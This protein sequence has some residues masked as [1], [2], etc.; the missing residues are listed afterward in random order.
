MCNYTDLVWVPVAAA[1]PTEGAWYH[2]TDGKTVWLAQHIK[3]AAGGWCNSDTW[4]DW[5]GEVKAWKRVP[6]PGPPPDLAQLLRMFN[7]D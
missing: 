7:R 6:D 1:E 4:E 3:T 5:D 2:V